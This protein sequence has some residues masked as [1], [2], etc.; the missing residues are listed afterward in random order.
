M[1]AVRST[2]GDKTIGAV[3]V[4]SVSGDIIIGRISALTPS[5][6]KLLYDASV[7]G[8]SLGVTAL[9]YNA[10]G[11][12]L[13][14]GAAAVT[15]DEVTA[16]AAAGTPPYTYAWSKVSGGS[17]WSILSP[18]AASTRFRYTTVDEG[19]SEFGEFKVTVTDARGRTGEAT[20]EASVYN[21]GTWNGL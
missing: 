18:T 17:G 3:S 21:Y 2:S 16:S 19:S 13:T 4:R 1:I 6:D 5:G 7:G 11:S 15:T 8:G 14:S 10:I 12:R 9:P 20:I